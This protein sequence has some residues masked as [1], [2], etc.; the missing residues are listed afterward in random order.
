M[1]SYLQAQQYTEQHYP[2][3]RAH[4]KGMF[5]ILTEKIFMDA[6]VHMEGLPKV[7]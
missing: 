7:R 3:Q 5:V 1:R 2:S 6:L 4:M